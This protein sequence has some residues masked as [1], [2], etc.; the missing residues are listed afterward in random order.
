MK[1]N[2]ALALTTVTLF[3]PWAISAQLISQEQS[4]LQGAQKHTRYKV[5]DTGSFGGPS[6]HMNLG[7]HILNNN[8]LFTGYADTAEPDP[9]APDGC[10]D[11]ET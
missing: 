4:G 1:S 10:W 11:G 6:S 5:I 8:G 2:L 9:Y 3:A 7:A